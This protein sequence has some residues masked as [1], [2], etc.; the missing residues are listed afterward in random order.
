MKKVQYFTYH[1]QS[2]VEI[3]GKQKTIGVTLYGHYILQTDGTVYLVFG[4][5]K[6]SPDDPFVKKVGVT[7]ASYR[8]H[9]TPFKTTIFPRHHYLHSS[10]EIM[11]KDLSIFIMENPRFIEQHFPKYEY[12]YVEVKPEKNEHYLMGLDVIR[13]TTT[14][15]TDIPKKIEE[16][17][18]KHGMLVKSPW[19]LPNNGTS[20]GNYVTT[21]NPNVDVKY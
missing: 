2:Q 11:L 5:S 14:P 15:K 10:E 13:R 18:I 1:H 7:I 20:S 3:N 9:N 17:K 16:L 19:S 8:Y 12:N 21:T 4:A 6:N